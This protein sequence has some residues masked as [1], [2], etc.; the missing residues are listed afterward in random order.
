MNRRERDNGQA[1]PGA[2]TYFAVL[3]GLEQGNVFVTQDRTEDLRLLADGSVAYE[4][5]GRGLSEVE[6][7]TL[8]YDALLRE[9]GPITLANALKHATIAGASL[10]EDKAARE[11]ISHVKT[12]LQLLL[13]REIAS[14]R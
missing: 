13:A 14:V 8:W 3:K 6:A 12:I 10:R 7:Q 4:V 5:L 1:V 9:A 11:A 2:R